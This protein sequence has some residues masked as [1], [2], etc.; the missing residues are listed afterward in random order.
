MNTQPASSRLSLLLT[1]AACA[2]ALTAC[3]GGGGDAGSSGTGA[4]PLPTGTDAID[5]YV[6]TIA[7]PCFQTPNVTDAT[8]G[9]KLYLKSTLRLTT[10]V[11]ASQVTGSFDYNYYDAATCTGTSRYTITITGASNFLSIDGTG[12]ASGKAVDKVTLGVGVFFPGITFGTS[13]TV[14]GVRF[15]G[16]P[17]NAQSAQTQKDIWQ[18]DAATGNITNGDFSNLPDAQG[19]PTVLQ[20]SPSFKKI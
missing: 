18:L 9:A 14:Q 10:K 13:Y 3:G 11:N 8:T 17:Y 1:A 12:T 7:G 20:S 19:Y 5:K 16:A 6:G 2:V 4:T 15:T